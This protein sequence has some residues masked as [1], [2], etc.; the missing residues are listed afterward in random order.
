MNALEQ[1]KTLNKN[2]VTVRYS[3]V[4]TTERE[5]KRTTVLY[6]ITQQLENKYNWFDVKMHKLKIL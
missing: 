4:M 2:T 6:A 3:H 5:I 1:S